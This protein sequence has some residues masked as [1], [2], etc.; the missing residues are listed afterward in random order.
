MIVTLL[1]FMQR[2]NGLKSLNLPGSFLNYLLLGVRNVGDRKPGFLSI[3]NSLHFQKR[4][5]VKVSLP[6]NAKMF[7]RCFDAAVPWDCEVLL[8]LTH[9]RMCRTPCSERTRDD[10]AQQLHF[11]QTCSLCVTEQPTAVEKRPLP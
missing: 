7:L 9:P 8:C 1:C 4:K 2:I 10:L 6:S 11:S 5:R 3:S